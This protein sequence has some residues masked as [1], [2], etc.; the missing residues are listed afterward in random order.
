M[1]ETK[2]YVWDCSRFCVNKKFHHC[3]EKK[4]LTYVIYS[5]IETRLYVT[6]KKL[7]PNCLFTTQINPVITNPVYNERLWPVP[8]F[9]VFSR[10]KLI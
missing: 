4:I 1:Y 9:N 7:S 3:D 2:V 6:N 8:S 5:Y 10:R